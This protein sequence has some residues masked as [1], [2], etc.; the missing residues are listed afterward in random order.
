[1]KSSNRLC[2][3]YMIYRSDPA[4]SNLFV[5]CRKEISKFHRD[6]FLDWETSLGC[7]RKT[8]RQTDRQTLYDSLIDAYWCLIQNIYTQLGGKMTPKVHCKLLVN[9]SYIICGYKLF[10]HTLTWKVSCGEHGGQYS[11]FK[12]ATSIEFLETVNCFLTVYYRSN[13]FP[14]LNCNQNSIINIFRSHS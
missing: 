6:S 1:M 7:N 10:M 12:L 5:A 8:D 13:T 3:S 9:I 4:R 2:G 11:T 14:L